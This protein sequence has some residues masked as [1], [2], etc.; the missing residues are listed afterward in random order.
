MNNQFRDMLEEIKQSK[1]S[2]PDPETGELKEVNTFSGKELF[3]RETN[4]DSEQS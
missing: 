1:Q 3:W 4:E 2:I